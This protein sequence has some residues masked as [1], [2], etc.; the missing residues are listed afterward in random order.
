MA[1][2]DFLARPKMHYVRVNCSGRMPRPTTRAG[3]RRRHGN[4]VS[5]E[6]HCDEAAIT[7]KNKKTFASFSLSINVWLSV[8]AD[9]PSGIP[10]ESFFYQQSGSH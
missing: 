1:A 8:S 3:M 4:L 7:K 6:P 10:P 9:Q 5:A 2:Q